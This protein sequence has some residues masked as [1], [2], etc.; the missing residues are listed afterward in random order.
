MCVWHLLF[1]ASTFIVFYFFPLFLGRILFTK[2]FLIWLSITD[3]WIVKNLTAR[4]LVGLRYWNEI[5]ENN[6]DVWYFECYVDENNVN[7]FDKWYFWTIQFVYSIFYLV[8]LVLRIISFNLK[9]LLEL[10]PMVIGGLVNLYAF[11]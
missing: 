5:D 6:D 7:S 3:F 8:I 11:Y 2:L 9:M 4:R 1:K 10:L